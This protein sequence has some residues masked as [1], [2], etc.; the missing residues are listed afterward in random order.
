MIPT[1][2]DIIRMLASGDCTPAQALAWLAQHE[3][4]EAERVAE[5]RKLFAAIALNG[6]LANP[7]YTAQMNDGA[8]SG[9]LASA[10]VYHADEL[11]AELRKAQP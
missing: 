10:A 1:V 4:L 7:H 11:I 6:L 3:A 9:T 8:C 5:D 2:E